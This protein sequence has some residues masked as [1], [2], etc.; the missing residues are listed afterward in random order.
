MIDGICSRNSPAAYI[1][2]VTVLDGQ[3]IKFGN[4]FRRNGSILTGHIFR[5]CTDEINTTIEHMLIHDISFDIM[6]IQVIQHD[7]LQG[8]PVLCH[9]GHTGSVDQ[10]DIIVCFSV[11]LCLYPVGDLQTADLNILCIL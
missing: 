9:T 6:N 2:Q 11:S 10:V 8:S 7:M 3:S 1:F 4:S 5:Q